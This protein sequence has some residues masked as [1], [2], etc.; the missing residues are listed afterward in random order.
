[1]RGSQTTARRRAAGVATIE[2]SGDPLMTF[3]IVVAN[4]PRVRT[5]TPSSPPWLR[6]PAKAPAALA[7]ASPVCMQMKFDHV[8]ASFG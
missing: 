2:R 7:A 4:P 5:I 3:E 6:P 8:L 1:M